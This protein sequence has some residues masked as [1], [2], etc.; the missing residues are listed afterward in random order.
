MKRNVYS[1]GLDYDLKKGSVEGFM[2]SHNREQ[3]ILLHAILHSPAVKD[4]PYEKRKRFH[5]AI[6]ARDIKNHNSPL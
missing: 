1:D 2:R 4:V 3:R 6:V 5:D